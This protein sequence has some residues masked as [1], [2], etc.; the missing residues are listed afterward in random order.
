MDRQQ[1]EPRHQ[2][3]VQGGSARPVSAPSRALLGLARGLRERD[4][5][6]VRAEYV[7]EAASWFP[8]RPDELAM[9][10]G[11]EYNLAGL[12]PDWLVKLVADLG[13][14]GLGDEAARVG[15][16][17]ARVDPDSRDFYDG[18]VAL[19]LAE[20]GAA[21]QAK[22]RIEANLTRW[23]DDFWTRFLAGDALLALGDLDGAKAHFEAAVEIADDTDDF[24]SRHDAVRR[25]RKLSRLTSQEDNPSGQRRQPKRKLSKSQR[26]QK[27]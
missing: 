17:L 4:E 3:A 14:A 25:L 5:R 9:A 6:A 10:V 26:K 22:A 1:C 2:P 24:E 15:D 8:G 20:A 16:A 13:R 11:E 23:P 21:E 12:L 18:S 27:R 7:V 19:A